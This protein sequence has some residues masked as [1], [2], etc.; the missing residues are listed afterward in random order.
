MV[1]T[2]MNAA[3][4][5][6]R[7]LVAG[8]GSIGRRHAR[9]LRSLGVNHLWVCDPSA[10]QREGLLTLT[11]SERVFPTYA[12]GL[13]ARPDAVFICTPPRLHIPMAI[14]AL[15]SGAHVFCE[16]PLTDSTDGLDTLRQTVADSGRQF[17]VGFCFRYH[18]GLKLARRMLDEGRIGRLISIRSRMGEHLPTV[19]PDYK[20][21]FTT[22]YSGAFD[23]TH[24]VDLACW[25]A[26]GLP[27]VNVASLYGKFS[28]VEMRA[29]DLV[30]LLVQFGD[31]CLA[32]VHLDFFSQPRSRVTELAGTE[33]TISVEFSSWDLCTIRVCTAGESVW[34]TQTLETDRDDMFRSEDAEFLAAIAGAGCVGVDLTEACRSLEILRAAH[35]GTLSPLFPRHHLSRGVRDGRAPV[36]AAL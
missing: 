28:D 23:L 2:G 16:K 12:A 35:E 5:D 36:P 27:V 34:K 18:E 1:V 10:Q 29:P 31:S 4:E 26:Q 24:E 19:R 3:A 8:C 13:E 30:E 7:I 22:Q 17:M 15:Q 21:L 14:E 6:I 25:F 33:G 20:T 9:I 11:P 32:S